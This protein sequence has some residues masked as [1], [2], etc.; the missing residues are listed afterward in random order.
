MNK[1]IYKMRIIITFLFCLLTPFFLFSQNQSVK[2]DYRQSL[3]RY[4]QLYQFNKVQKKEFSKLQKE[5]QK[6]DAQLANLKNT[7]YDR[8][9]IKRDHLKKVTDKSIYNILDEKQQAI[10]RQQQEIKTKKEIELKSRLKKEGASPE[11][12]KRALLELN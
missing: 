12:I 1:Q 9:L 8:Y 7:D 2:Q 4:Q 3:D 11:A 6:K 5:F 10:Y